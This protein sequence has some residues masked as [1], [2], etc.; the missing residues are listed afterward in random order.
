MKELSFEE[1]KGSIR[2][3]KFMPVY[4]FQGDE[5]Y[6]ID[7]LTDLL[8]ESVVD[9]SERDFNQ[10]V[11]YG[12][13]TDV[14]TVINACR[15]Y[16][17]M[18]ERQLVVVKEAQ[19]LKNID[20]L[21]HYVKNPL[22]STVLVINYKYGKLDG[23]KK[24]TGEI[25]KAGIVF[26]SKKMYDNQVPGF[27]VN[28]L[29]DKQIGIETQTAQILTDYL[30]N[31]LSKITNELDKL[32]I[33]LPAENKR[34]TPEIIEK[35]IGISKDFNNFELQRAI[36]FGDVLKANRIAQYFEQNQKN[37]PYI[38][39]LNVLF[40]FFSNLMICHFE[41]NKSKENLMPILG[42]RSAWDPRLNDYMDALRRYNAFKVMDNIALIREY[43]AKGKG[44]ENPAT[45]AG[46][47]LIELIYK[48][49]H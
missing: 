9:E 13:E 46:K 42:I 19:N 34:I 11:V 29:K 23:R 33:T 36:A 41:Q 38:L 44:F 4:L 40:S 1:I 17:M 30:G 37:N 31:D 3:K 49:M 10:T 6:Y 21:S 48:L 45:P 7:H 18:A 15:R 35:N 20:D 26:E 22:N 16:P 27:I 24:L 2:L 12:L 5:S 39:T 28:Y 47:L 32:A 8:L 43:D 25:A 14:A